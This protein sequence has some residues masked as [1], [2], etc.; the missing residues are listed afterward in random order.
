MAGPSGYCFPKN[1]S[2]VFSENLS[3]SLVFHST[4][5]VFFIDFLLC[6]VSFG[7][8]CLFPGIFLNCS[9]LEVSGSPYNYLINVKTYTP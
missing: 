6:L 3:F 2:V 5:I 1:T 7:I 8:S 9:A 4:F